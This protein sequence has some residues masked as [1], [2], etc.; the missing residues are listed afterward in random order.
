MKQLNF[1]FRNI[2]ISVFTF[3]VILMI[4][5]GNQTQS[6]SYSYYNLYDDTTPDS[7][8]RANQFY[9]T[10]IDYYP[11]EGN[12]IVTGIRYL[13][14]FFGTTPS[15]CN[16]DFR[17]KANGADYTTYWD[18]DL[19]NPTG[20]AWRS[21]YFTSSYVIDNDPT[22]EFVNSEASTFSVGI[23]WD[24]TGTMISNT[25]EE[26]IP[27]TVT[28]PLGTAA[29][30][31]MK[32]EQ[33]PTLALESYTSGGFTTTDHVDAYY[34]YM[35][36]GTSYRI[37]L[38]RTT[39]YSG[40][41]MNLYAYDNILTSSLDYWT[42]DD[43]QDEMTY[44]PS[45]TG[46]YILLVEDMTP[47]TT[48]SDYTL[49]F[50]DD[51]ELGMPSLTSPSDSAETYDTTP[52][53]D[54]SAVS[55]A[56]EYQIQVDDYDTFTSP[57]R[58]VHTSNS[59]Y[60]VP[61][62]LAEDTYYWRVRAKDVYGKYGGWSN[63][64]Q[65]TILSQND[66]GSGDDAGDSFASAM[67]ISTGHISGRLISGQDDDDY[68]E[69]EVEG[70]K[71][72]IYTDCEPG[73]T[74]SIYIYNPSQN[75]MVSETSISST[76][77]L[78]F[79]AEES[80]T[81]FVRVHRASGEGEYE[82]TLSLASSG[83]GDLTKWLIIGV[84]ALLGIVILILIIV[85][86]IRR[87]RKPTEKP[88]IKIGSHEYGEKEINDTI[89][90]VESMIA[91]EE[92]RDIK[93]KVEK[94]EAEMTDEKLKNIVVIKGR[95]TNG[96]QISIEVDKNQKVINLDHKTLTSIDLSPLKKCTE[97]ELLNLEDNKLSSIDLTPLKT[98]T[99]LKGIGLANNKLTSID[100]SPLKTC[101]ELIAIHLARNSLGLSLSIDLSPLQAC[102]EL[103][104][105]NLDANTLLRIDL[106]PL[107]ACTK[108]TELHLEF[109]SFASIDLSPLKACTK[110]K[111]LYLGY[112]QLASI[113]L[114][115]LKACT[116]LQVLNLEFNQLAS[117]DLSPLKACTELQALHLNNNKLPSSFDLSSLKACTKLKK[118]YH[119][120]LKFKK[121]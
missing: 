115:P 112:N 55:G 114:S 65:F 107:K 90:V 113:D 117:I 79:I 103:Q 12:L 75:L 69:F 108:L 47:M 87:K 54:W 53:L 109:N 38:D 73:L 56:D 70:T 6:T 80:G 18:N 15:S 20:Y 118:L 34:I 11:G 44:T 2:L 43:P 98:C 1:N 84:S 60:T 19:P 72:T 5:Q 101:T 71:I 93:K 10:G 41:K 50:T 17:I 116:E 63:D 26:L 120:D 49:V 88:T 36:S 76:N 105:L 74:Y 40:I 104:A 58:D 42:I 23:G 8:G 33:V 37:I 16:L 66:G 91:S 81:W 96:K 39:G 22:I 106:S 89:K 94:S 57:V 102:T 99:K 29:I 97:L 95:K 28:R 82:L 3:C 85:I 62:S 7:Y 64:N 83:L 59:Y 35:Y 48:E 67:S 92:D 77:T 121:T 51:A 32:Y 24:S 25:F 45:T 86:A 100:F 78:T 119:G 30:I 61:T 9:N 13:Y 31:D 4:L 68:Y 21:L 14:D 52:T 111:G 110:L 27:G 46:T